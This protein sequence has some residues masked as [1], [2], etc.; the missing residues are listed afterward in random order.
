MKLKIGSPVSGD[1]FF[2]R[3]D[4]TARL[5]R[6]LER[7][8]ISFLA[9]R[10]TGK[11]SVLI[12]LED[13]AP[14]DHPHFRINLE[15]CTSP[16]EMMAA[17][18]SALSEEKPRW[19]QALGKVKDSALSAI[20]GIE[21]VSIAGNEIRLAKG[22]DWKKP[23]EAFLKQLTQH[24]GRITFL[25][26]EFPILVDAAA[27]QDRDDCEAMLRWFREWRQRTADSGIRFLV[28]GSIGLA[29]VVRRHNFADTVNDFDSLDLPPLT[30][31]DALK[32]IAASRRERRFP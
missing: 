20:R 31:T 18:M 2:P 22:S 1:N 29:N 19:R 13:T 15:T 6:A 23:A 25:L 8:H 26:D 7:D 17:L 16:S 30:E 9:P 12:H 21:T 14:E 3:P 4:V 5:R 32:L 11:T 27:K 24:D 28:T 10:R